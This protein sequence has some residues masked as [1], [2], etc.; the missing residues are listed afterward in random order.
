L[1]LQHRDDDEV[2]D[3]LDDGDDSEASSDEEVYYQTVAVGGR[4]GRRGVGGGATQCYVCNSYMIPHN[5]VVF[6][7]KNAECYIIVLNKQQNC[8]SEEVLFLIR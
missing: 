6:L 8:E 4:S 5:N 1:M 2:E 3:E 7:F